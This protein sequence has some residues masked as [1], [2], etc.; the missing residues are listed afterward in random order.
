MKEIISEKEARQIL[1]AE[2][3]VVLIDY[4]DIDLRI[5]KVAEDFV[6]AVP[7]EWDDE[8]VFDDDY[9]EVGTPDRYEYTDFVGATCYEI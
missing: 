8:R 2:M 3:H 5:K 9:I 6:L 1:K 4:C 7:I